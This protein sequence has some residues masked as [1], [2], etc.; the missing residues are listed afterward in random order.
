MVSL[1]APPQLE[2]NVL[3]QIAALFPVG[4]IGGA[5]RSSEE[6]NLSAGSPY[7]VS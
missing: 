2:M 3:A 6:P 7:R 1:K 4:F 5:S